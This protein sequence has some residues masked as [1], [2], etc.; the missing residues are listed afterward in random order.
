[1]I[2]I[3]AATLTS[4]GFDVLQSQDGKQGLEMALSFHP[5]LILLDLLLP[6][7][8]GLEVL[9]ALRKHKHGADIPV[10]I[11]TNLDENDEIYNTART[12]ASAYIIKSNSS[13][14]SIVN[15]VQQQ[16]SNVTASH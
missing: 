7:M 9:K 16:L 11:L 4:K 3:L 2:K 1:M 5:D 10:M 6:T 13:L 14:E 8:S 12:A 15:E